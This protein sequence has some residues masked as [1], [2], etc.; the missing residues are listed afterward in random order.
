MKNTFSSLVLA[1]AIALGGIVSGGTDAK[2]AVAEVPDREWSWEGPF[3]TFDRAAL[4][5][6]LQVYREVCSACHSLELVAY[7][8]LQD[9]G[10]SEAEVK[11]IAEQYEVL[12]GPDDEGEMYL[13]PGQPADRFVSPF[14]NDN[15]ARAANGGA[16]PPDLSLMT[17]ARKNGADYLHALLTGYGEPP[18][19][20]ELLAGMNYNKYFSGQ[21]IAMAPPL[22]DDYVEYADGTEA[23]LDQIA[24]DLTTFLAWTAEPELEERKRLGVKV[25]IFLVVFTGFAYALKR[26]IWSDVH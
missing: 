1:A 20:F 19:D 5:R 7:R 2:A 24:A 8:H 4:R 25:I 11:A 23:T 15:A 10:F 21:Q 18:A 12:D 13:R 14:P 6:G 22:G 17:K 26:K 3:G 9:V 16:L